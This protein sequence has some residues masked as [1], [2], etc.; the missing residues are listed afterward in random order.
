MN[1]SW[2]VACHSAATLPSDFMFASVTPRLVSN[3]AGEV[4]YSS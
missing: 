4:V 3:V 2:V 1:L